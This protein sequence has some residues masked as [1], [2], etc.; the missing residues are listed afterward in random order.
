MRAFAAILA[1]LLL[2]PLTAQTPAQLKQ[3]LRA[4]ETAAKQD[5]DALF[6]AGKWAEEKGLAA[7]SKRIFQAVLKIKPDHAEA[8]AALGNELVDGKW[9]SAK[10]AEAARK[11][12]REAEFKAKGLVEVSGVWVE[13]DHVD[14]AKRGLFHFEG[15]RVGKEEI[16]ALQSG[17]VRHPITDELIDGKHLEQAKEGMFPIGTEGRWVSEKEADNYHSDAKRPWVFR[18][19]YC[20]I[21]ST[22]SLAKIREMKNVADSAYEKI[23]PILGNH[24]PL[25]P[26][27]PVIHVAT[28]ENEFKELGTQLGDET[29]STGAFLAREGILGNL[30]Y[31]SGFR[32]AIC[33]WHKDWGPY[34]L[35]HA[36]ALAYV[37]GLCA[38]AGAEVPLWFLTAFGGYASRFANDSDAGWFGVQHQKKGGVKNLKGFFA[39]F[40][41]NGEMESTMIDYNIYQAGLLISYLSR[42]RDDK[43]IE[44]MKNVTDMLASRKAKGIDKVITKLAEQFA[45]NESAIAAHLQELIKLAPK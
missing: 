32:P 6:A 28:T 17:K 9:L 35:R 44:A 41:I 15:Q 12:A 16:L 3:E 30:P 4:K 13:K 24:E 31:Q 40:A 22:Q 18:T 1:C 42:G 25:P 21:I 39:G 34:Y 10:D 43:L 14:D 38:D 2:A 45:A 20:T 23:R 37:H 19:T 7:E 36:T 8:N 26:N 33:H 29:S 27:R 11:K 5:P